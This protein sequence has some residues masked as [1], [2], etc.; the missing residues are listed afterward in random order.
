MNEVQEF[1]LKRAMQK[2]AADA[3]INW[4]D[5]VKSGKGIQL[6][7]AVEQP[8]AHPVKSE[9]ITNQYPAP[10][11][12]SDKAW[13]K[14]LDNTY[15]TGKGAGRH[16]KNIGNAGGNALGGFLE[17]LTDEYTA[18]AIGNVAADRVHNAVDNIDIN[19]KGALPALKRFFRDVENERYRIN[20]KP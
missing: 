20:K 6:P 18:A 9:W 10:F 19:G 7:L 12:I 1:I 16:L 13:R 3:E 14:I 15:A 17:G 2:V 5:V 4:D 8:V 11:N